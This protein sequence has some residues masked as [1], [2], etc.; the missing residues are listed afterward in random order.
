MSLGDVDG[1]DRARQFGGEAKALA[2]Q[3]HLS[4]SD[5]CV[6]ESTTAAGMQVAA[7]LEVARR[8]RRTADDLCYHLAEA[9]MRRGVEP[10]TLNWND[11]GS[12]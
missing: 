9:A 12:D 2:D 10:R 11:G 5:R 7:A 1:L 8:L 4:L 3:L 6:D